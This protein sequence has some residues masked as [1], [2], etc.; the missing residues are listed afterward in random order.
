MLTHVL[1]Q[2]DAG[3]VLDLKG[4]LVPIDLSVSQPALATIVSPQ[5]YEKWISDELSRLSAVAAYGGYL[6]RRGLY[7]NSALFDGDDQ[8]RDIHL[9]M[10]LWAPAGTVVLA[11]IQGVVHSFNYNAGIGNYGPTVIL[12]HQSQDATFY[13]LYGHLSLGSITEL[14]VGEVIN[15]GA[16]LGWLGDASVNGNYAPHLHFQIIAEL[17]EYVGDYPGVCSADSLEP[18]KENCPDPNLLLKIEG[19]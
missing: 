8:R 15:K 3:P 7:N 18:Y 2:L 5:D 13:T 4:K 16:V 19:P 1:Q 14:E 12:R 11:P 9:G 10:D 17:G 6:E